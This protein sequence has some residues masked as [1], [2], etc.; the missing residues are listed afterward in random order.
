MYASFVSCLI[1]SAAPAATNAEH[2]PDAR[3]MY[4]C[5]FEKE[6]D[7]NHDAFPDGW[8]R[9]R[10]AEFP[11]YL[12]VAI[13]E[14]DAHAGRA[15]L[16]MELDGGA[17][18]IFS[19][20]IEVGPEFSYVLECRLK[21]ER[22]VHDVAFM[23]LAFYDVQQKRLATFTSDRVRTA[24]DWTKLS[25]GPV[26][27]PMGDVAFAVLGLHLHPT[28]RFD[29]RGAA[30]FDDVWLAHLPRM[31]V[32]TNSPHN[33]LIEKEPVT[34]ACRASGILERDPD[35][36]F[37]L[38]DV[39]GQAIDQESLKM[40]GQAVQRKTAKA[41]NVPG[42]RR[43]AATGYAGRIEWSPKAMSPGFYRVR[44][45]MKGTAALMQQRDVTFAVI[46][47]EKQRS[48]GEFGWSLPKGDQPLGLNALDELLGHAAVSW[49]KFPVW[50]D[51]ADTERGGQ[52]TRFA[53]RL[54]NRGITLVGLL[55][56]PPEN[57]RSQLG[58]SKGLF[59]ANIFTSDPQIWYPSLEPVMTRLSSRVNW[60]Q[61]GL[62]NDTSFV[63]YPNVVAT[64]K[65]IKDQL[66]KVGLDARLGMSW[67]WTN[68]IHSG[69]DVPF[70]FLAMSAD[71]PLRGGELTE[72]LAATKSSPAKRWV[73][74]ELL[75]R[76]EYPMETRAT[77]LVE[78]MMSAKIG[79]ADAVFV[80]EPFSTERGLMNDD[81]T[82]GELFMTWRTAASALGGANYLGQLELKNGSKNRIFSRGR[83]AVMVIW[84]ERPVQETVYLGKAVE[85]IDLWGRVRSVPIMA[86]GQE[87]EV[88]PL[89][90]Y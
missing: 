16:R 87:I 24:P 45:T 21:T 22:L 84:N 27:P 40:D 62:D 4:H 55:D 53:E 88:G 74:L 6:V 75:P 3:E 67:R 13:V 8:S 52:L 77:D 14:G 60:W 71:P 65:T 5:G 85:Q 12:R 11:H 36:T 28:R 19:P 90:T 82:P 43:T 42:L 2:H 80:P 70:E 18:S 15:V 51:A 57:V 9:R 37:E 17:A 86:R 48:G 66:G 46:Q 49:V 72:Y 34:I 83:D 89:P 41:L 33:I 39:A 61:L 50:H 68:E 10:D 44:V 79:G 25:I 63:G 59:A 64:I 7:T 81:G 23:T 29:I 30:V 78:R 38:V 76:G 58:D 69:K 31:N 1:L 26:A 54:H 20:P 56:Q 47:K 73:V 32:E 35:V